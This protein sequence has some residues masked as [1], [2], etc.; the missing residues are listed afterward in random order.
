[1]CAHA[2]SLLGAAVSCVVKDAAAAARHVH[3][4]Q[5][6]MSLQ[7]L[8]V[9][10]LTFCVAACPACRTACGQSSSCGRWRSITCRECRP[11]WT[12]SLL[13]ACTL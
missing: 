11:D 8:L 10:S 2:P 13:L 4:D 7:R 3:T 1:M 12:S 9:L 6:G 5:A